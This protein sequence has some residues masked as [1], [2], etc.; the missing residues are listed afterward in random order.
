[1]PL[2]SE[3]W[4]Y[5]QFN[6]HEINHKAERDPAPSEGRGSELGY[7][8]HPPIHRGPQRFSTTATTAAG[9]ARHPFTTP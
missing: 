4:I 9:P 2:P 1:V 7:S 6:N 3:R 5:I 8:R